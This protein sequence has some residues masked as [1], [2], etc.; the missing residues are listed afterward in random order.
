MGT[1]FSGDDEKRIPMTPCSGD[2]GNL[3]SGQPGASCKNRRFYGG[4][5]RFGFMWYTSGINASLIPGI[6]EIVLDGR[7]G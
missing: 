4:N 1:T 3:N 2:E 5:L 7:V 6:D